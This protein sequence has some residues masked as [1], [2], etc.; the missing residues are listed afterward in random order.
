MVSGALEVLVAGSLRYLE[1]LVP[2]WVF[3]ARTSLVLG[4]A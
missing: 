2:G 1:N 4:M 3:A